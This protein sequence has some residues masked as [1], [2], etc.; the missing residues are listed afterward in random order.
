MGKLAG[1]GKW[2]FGHENSRKRGD[3]PSARI[4]RTRLRLRAATV[5]LFPGLST[6][7]LKIHRHTRQPF[8][9]LCRAPPT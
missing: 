1:L 4:L 9:F 5:P 3:A 8:L 7:P 6:K 2:G